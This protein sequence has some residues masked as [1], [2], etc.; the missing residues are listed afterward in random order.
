[1]LTA[2]QISEFIDLFEDAGGDRTISTLWFNPIDWRDSVAPMMHTEKRNVI[3]GISVRLNPLVPKGKYFIAQRGLKPPS[4][5]GIE[6]EVE[7]RTRL[8]RS[9]GALQNLRDENGVPV[10]EPQKVRKLI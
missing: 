1:M 10:N 5:D 8:N 4:F 6:P 3:F 9:M 2:N 7:F